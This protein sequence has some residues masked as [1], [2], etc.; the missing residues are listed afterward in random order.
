MCV[1]ASFI[2]SFINFLAATVMAEEQDMFLSTSYCFSLVLLLYFKLHCLRIP[3]GT[4]TL[5]H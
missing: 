2:G 4:S 5:L 1:A 3:A